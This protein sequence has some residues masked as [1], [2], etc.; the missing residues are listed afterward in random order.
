MVGAGFEVTRLAP[1]IGAEIRMSVAAMLDGS[2][3]G[4]ILA[5][6]EE[7]GVICFPQV[8]LDDAQQLAFSRTLGEVL[9]Q[10]R[11]GIFTVSIDPSVNPSPEVAEYQRGSVFWHFDTATSTVPTRASILTARALSASGGDTLFANTYAA[12]EDLSEDDKAYLATIRVLH[13]T[14]AAARL[15]TPWPS[16]AKLRQWQAIPTAT[17]P[18]VWTHRSGRK[19]L[20]L[21]ATASHV[22]GMPLDEGRALLCRLCEW[23]TQPRYVYRHQWRLGDLVMWDNTGT[24]HRA[25]PYGE[26]SGRRMHRTTLVGHEP[27]V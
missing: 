26:D 2:A 13:S 15:V 9:P 17:H 8:S 5:V 14:E 7:R 3:A 4:R 1:R 10:G 16:Y 23:A 27:L 25:T 12:W 18:L 19:S 24:L 22:E 20:V 6:L 21:G 11:D